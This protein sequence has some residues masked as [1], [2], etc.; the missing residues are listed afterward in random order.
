MCEAK[1]GLGDRKGREPE[2][3]EGSL[4]WLLKSLE[5]VDLRHFAQ[6]WVCFQSR[7]G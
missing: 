2:V 6:D 7:C 3:E 4:K 5:C 1:W